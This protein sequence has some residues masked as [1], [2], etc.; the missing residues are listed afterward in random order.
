M[1]QPIVGPGLCECGCGQKTN[2]AAVTDRSRGSVKGEPTRFAHGH[3]RNNGPVEFWRRINTITLT[4]RGCLEWPGPFHPSGYG[5]WGSKKVHQ[6]MFE[7]AHG[8]I[9]IGHGVLHRCD[10]PPCCNPAHLFSGTQA[11]N[12]AD[13]RIKGRGPRSTRRLTPDDVRAIRRRY[14]GGG[15]SMRALATEYMISPTHARCII[16]RLKW[17]ESR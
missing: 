6:I 9:P 16:R 3:S 7:H 2:L 17:S 12:M 15:I 5:A 10:N 1:Q 8:P 11:D 4:A 13:M 14:A